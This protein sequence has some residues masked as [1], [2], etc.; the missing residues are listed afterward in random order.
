MEIEQKIQIIKLYDIYYQLLTKKQQQI[1][2]LV[3]D[4]DYMV[5]EVATKL[6]VSNAAVSKTIT[7]IKRKLGVYEEKLQI[8]SN[9]QRN[10]VML[11]EN[12]VSDDIIAKIK[13]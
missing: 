13:K 6:G 9:Y 7:E 10:I 12:N 5:S 4:D 11:R 2:E 1:F 8:L 3:F